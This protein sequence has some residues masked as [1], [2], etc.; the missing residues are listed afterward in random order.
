VFGESESDR[1]ASSNDDQR[2]NGYLAFHGGLRAF[3]R[4]WPSGA[5]D[6]SCDVVGDV[7]TIRSTGNG[8]NFEWLTMSPDW[9]VTSRNV[10]RPQRFQSPGVNAFNDLIDAM[11]TGRPPICS[12]EDGRAALEIAI[13]LRDSHRRGGVRVQMPIVD[14]TQG[15]R[16]EDV[17]RSQ[18][19]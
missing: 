9:V 14:R 16:S 12:G 2:I 15:I 5:L 3:L 13:A 8:A 7:G 1:H 17:I 18:S 11:F 19:P 4:T 6:W 10:P